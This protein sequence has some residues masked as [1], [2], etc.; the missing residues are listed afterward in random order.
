MKENE[1]NNSY[2]KKAIALDSGFNLWRKLAS[3]PKTGVALAVK[4]LLGLVLCER[5]A[6]SN[7]DYNLPQ[8]DVCTS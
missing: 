1:S 4:H 3:S 7:T 5:L 2:L 6:R 8:K